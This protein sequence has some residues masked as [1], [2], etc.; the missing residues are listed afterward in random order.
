MI[1]EILAEIFTKWGVLA[2]TLLLIPLTL[3]I[4]GFSDWSSL[5]KKQEN[6]EVTLTTLGWI[7]LG[8]AAVLIFFFL[9]G[10]IG[11]QFREYLWVIDPYNI[12]I[13]ITIV[14]LGFIIAS[15]TGVLSSED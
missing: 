12:A 11:N 3:G 2:V 1:S 6:N 13:S 5:L 9:Y 15:V 10:T 8:V 7:I 4:F 14:I